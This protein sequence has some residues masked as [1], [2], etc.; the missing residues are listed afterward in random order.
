MQE[1]LT[2]EHFLN[3]NPTHIKIST[4]MLLIARSEKFYR[5]IS[6]PEKWGIWSIIWIGNPACNICINDISILSN[7]WNFCIDLLLAI[8]PDGLVG[9]VY[10]PSTARSFKR[11]HRHLLSLVKD[12]N[13]SFN[14]V[15]TENR[16]S[17]VLIG[18]WDVLFDEQRFFWFQK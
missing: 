2:K 15:P 6:V 9:C 10:I 18:C 1:D 16:V 8:L 13:L 5:N 14:T 7:L 11:R 12:L 3:I 17:W 4:T